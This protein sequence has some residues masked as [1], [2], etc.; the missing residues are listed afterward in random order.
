MDPGFS[1]I[2]FLFWGIKWRTTGW[3]LEFPHMYPF[4]AGLIMKDDR[5]DPG[6]SSIFFIFG[7]MNYE[8]QQDG[9]WIF[10][11]IF[12]FWGDEL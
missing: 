3:T 12:Y 6:F 5:M 4:F 7:V 9:P 1:S 10:L 8:G 2:F 11:Y